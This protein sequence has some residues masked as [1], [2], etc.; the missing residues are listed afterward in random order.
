M[1]SPGAPLHLRPMG[2]LLDSE[3]RVGHRRAGMVPGHCTSS[4]S[5]LWATLSSKR[6]E[7]S[8]LHMGVCS[9]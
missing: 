7:Q 8:E 1:L 5:P 9:D 6:G 3:T 2:H 4:A